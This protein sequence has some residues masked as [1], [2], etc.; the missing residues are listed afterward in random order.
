MARKPRPQVTSVL[1]IDYYCGANVI[2]KTP[3]QAQSYL[4]GFAQT[5]KD[6]GRPER[7]EMVLRSM[8]LLCNEITRP[9][10]PRRKAK[11]AKP[12][13]ANTPVR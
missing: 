6:E 13:S 1:H 2:M 7:G 4:R 11:I 3:A 12:K 5:L 9:K 10:R 8:Q